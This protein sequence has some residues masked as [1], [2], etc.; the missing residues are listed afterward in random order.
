M[1]IISLVLL[2]LKL[3]SIKHVNLFTLGQI[4]FKSTNKCKF[5]IEISISFNL[6]KTQYLFKYSINF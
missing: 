3:L 5:D 1:F 6:S 4:I 2:Y